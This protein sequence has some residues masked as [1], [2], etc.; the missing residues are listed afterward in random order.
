[1]SLDDFKGNIPDSWLYEDRAKTKLYTMP[2]SKGMLVK[3]YRGFHDHAS[4][5]MNKVIRDTDVQGGGVL[6][7]DIAV[8]RDAIYHVYG[9]EHDPSSAGIIE[10]SINPTDWNQ[11]VET[12]SIVERFY[13]GFSRKLNSTEIRVNTS[14]AAQV[15]DGSPKR[16][17]AP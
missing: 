15:I 1:M 3:V 14:H 12:K 17:L 5:Y 11:L 7:R 2:L 8:A 16:L 10:I 4:T 9:R 13:Y 6:S